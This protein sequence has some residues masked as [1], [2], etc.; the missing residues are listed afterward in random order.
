MSLIVIIGKSKLY[1]FLVF[2]LSSLGPIVPMQLPKLL[3]QM[4]K[5]LLVSITLLGPI[6][7]CH[8]P[9][10]PV[11]G[12]LLAAYWSPVKGWHNKIALVFCLV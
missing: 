10:L 4:T 11:T 2:G 3:G 7:C 1:G 8:Q 9:S 6:K 12:C 5:Y